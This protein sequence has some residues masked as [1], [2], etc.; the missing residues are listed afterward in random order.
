MSLG[1][2]SWSL[3]GGLLCLVLQ[4]FT[5]LHFTSHDS[6]R[7][8]M[9]TVCKGLGTGLTTSRAKVLVFFL[10]SIFRYEHI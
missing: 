5:S 7:F 9:H 1:L 2:S 3:H 8:G 10:F 6:L 4:S